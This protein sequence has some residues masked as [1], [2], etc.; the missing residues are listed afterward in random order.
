MDTLE[1]LK[2]YPD[3]TWLLP[4]YF[5]SLAKIKFWPDWSLNIHFNYINITATK[6]FRKTLFI[7]TKKCKKQRYIIFDYL[8]FNAVIRL[9]VQVTFRCWFHQLYKLR[10][11]YKASFH[12]NFKARYQPLIFVQIDRNFSTHVFLHIGTFLEGAPNEIQ[13]FFFFASP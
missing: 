13:K 5:V 7:T 4:S 1:N 3:L 6:K 10:L 11:V 8:Y 2:C 12:K 9:L